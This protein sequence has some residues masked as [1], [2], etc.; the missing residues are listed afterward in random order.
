MLKNHKS[1]AFLLI[2][3]LISLGLLVSLISIIG[4]WQLRIMQQALEVQQYA[5]ALN[6][7]ENSLEQFLALA[8]VH[9]FQV[10]N[11]QINATNNT[12]YNLELQIKE[13]AKS[14]FCL[15]QITVNWQSKFS[16]QQRFLKLDTGIIN[17]AIRGD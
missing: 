12:V 7:A 10:K 11:W 13:L 8:D 9:L 17:Y 6:L 5:L 3:L 15:V 1:K 14:K 16:N 2:E 4:Y